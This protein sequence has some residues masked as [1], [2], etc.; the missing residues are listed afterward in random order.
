LES[1]REYLL[2]KHGDYPSYHQVSR[3]VYGRWFGQL[4]LSTLKLQ[5]YRY[6]ERS[7][8]V[9]G[10]KDRFSAQTIADVI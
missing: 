7:M 9:Q 6:L 3:D 1:L 2:T 10:R 8:L 5:V 4:G